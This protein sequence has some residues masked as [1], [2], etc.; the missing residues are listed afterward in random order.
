MK[1]LNDDN[2]QRRLEQ[3]LSESGE[4]LSEIEKEDIK[5]YQFLFEELE[6]EPA[7]GLPYNFAAKVRMRIEAKVKRTSDIKLYLYAALVGIAGFG[8]AY[9]MLVFYNQQA[10]SQFFEAVSNFKWG[11]VLALICFLTIQYLDQKLVKEHKS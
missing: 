9:C 6:Q 7:E 11:F 3:G 4:S 1:K 10:A 2:I 5:A 8:I